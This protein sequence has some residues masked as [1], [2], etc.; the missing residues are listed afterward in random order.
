MLNLQGR[1]SQ[2]MHAAWLASEHGVPISL[3]NT[4]CEIGVHVAT[5]LPEVKWLENS[6]IGWD[7]LIAE[8]IKFENGYAIAPNRPGHGL[9]LSQA[10]HTEFASPEGI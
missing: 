6:F 9:T 8:P 5:A 2:V 3:G 4:T 7:A 10:A 1:I